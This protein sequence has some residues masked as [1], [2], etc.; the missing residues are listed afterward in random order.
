M[1]EAQSEHLVSIDWRRGKWADAKGKYSRE[2]TCIKSWLLP[3]ACSQTTYYPWPSN[4]RRVIQF[5]TTA[6]YAL[7]LGTVSCTCPAE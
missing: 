4:H 7:S 6:T 3:K 2:H 5:E 1:S